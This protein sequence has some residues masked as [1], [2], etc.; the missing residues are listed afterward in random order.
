MAHHVCPWWAGYALLIP[1]RRWTH[2]PER[3]LGPLVREGMTVLEPGPG[4][5]YFTLDLARMVGA[6]GRVVAVAVPF[7][8]RCGRGRRG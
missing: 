8:F 1:L 6:S 3:W 7:R 5:G 2:N 4:M